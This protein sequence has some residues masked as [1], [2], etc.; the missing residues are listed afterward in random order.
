MLFKELLHGNDIYYRK[1]LCFEF[2]TRADTITEEKLQLLK[3]WIGHDNIYIRIG[4]EASDDL[5]RNSWLNKRMDRQQIEQCIS[6]CH[7]FHYK[8][9]ANLLI[10]IPG[11]TERLSLKVVYDSILWLDK[12]GV[13]QI[14]CSVLS[15][16]NHTLQGYLRDHL[17]ENEELVEVG[18]GNGIHTGIPWLFSVIEFL[19]WVS[20]HKEL[21]KKITFGQ[22]ESTYFEGSVHQ[23]YNHRMNCDCYYKTWSAI[24]KIAL[25]KNW[26]IVNEI[27]EDSRKDPCYVEYEKLLEKQQN[28][29]LVMKNLLLVEKELSKSLWKQDWKRYHNQYVS[30]ILQL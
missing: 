8:V 22:F 4:V 18:I 3:S 15:R 17:S 29:N 14:V 25:E 5:V 9:S 19:K 21:Q 6:L 23:A 1:P 11:F 24:Q 2:E 20:E 10:G 13:D 7:E 26:N 16:K 30:E 12:L 27:Y 28:V